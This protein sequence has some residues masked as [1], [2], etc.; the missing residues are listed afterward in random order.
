VAI[1]RPPSGSTIARDRRLSLYRLALHPSQEAADEL[2]GSIAA[3]DPFHWD[4]YT[5]TWLVAEREAALRVLDD[6][7]FSSR[8]HRV[9]HPDIMQPSSRLGDMLSRQLL[10]LDGA[11]HARLRPLVV[12]ALSGR[13]IRGLTREI[14]ALAEQACGAPDRAVLD[15]VGDVACPVPMA[16]IGLLL[17]LP[18]T[19][20]DNLRV[21]SDA[22]T[23][24]ITG[25]DR[26]TDDATLTALESFIDFALDVVRCKRRHPADDATSELIAAADRLG[27]FDDM[28]LA[29]NLV[30]LVASGHQTTSGF[31]A[32]AVLN[33]LGPAAERRSEPFD[34]EAALA[35]V[36]PSRFI[37]RTASRDV[38]INGRLI[39]AGQSV[40][41]LLASV[42]RAYASRAAPHLA[43][44]HGPHRCPG[45]MLARLEGRL[46][47]NTVLKRCHDAIPGADTVR[48]SDNINLPRPESLLL[49]RLGR[50]GKGESGD[51]TPYL[52]GRLQASRARHARRPGRGSPRLDA[53]LQ[54]TGPGQRPA[55]RRAA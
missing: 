40:L 13:R 46:V 10:F 44:G 5:K 48:W 41:V 33:R 16:V 38:R 30:M 52:P 22:Y 45:A 24:L 3:E 19:D 9:A 49:I 55:R 6:P 39:T 35:E 15:V 12:R 27:G 42:N 26:T 23:R 1:T 25:I 17:G 34:V 14:T 2:F 37:G 36:S 8:P 4:P 20:Y 32:G 43:F 54:G 31:I 21:M 53:D 50:R 47:V 11:A 29:A 18:C 51:R 28:D 7:A